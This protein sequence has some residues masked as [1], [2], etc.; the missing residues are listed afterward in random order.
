LETDFDS[1]RSTS[2]ER[3]RFQVLRARAAALSGKRKL[4]VLE[5]SMFADGDGVDGG[6]A[7]KQGE[8]EG[9]QKGESKVKAR[10]AEG[11]EGISS[12]L[13]D[14][15]FRLRN[16]AAEVRKLLKASSSPVSQ[17]ELNLMKVCCGLPCF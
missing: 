2:E 6:D 4:L 12:A 17:D 14:A 3:Q 13:M 16:S 11:E 8:G 5:D 15:D 7:S 10:Q 1:R 9:E